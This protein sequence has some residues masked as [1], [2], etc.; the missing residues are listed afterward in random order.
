MAN[1]Y[2][3]LKIA[4]NASI[5]E[6]ENAVDTHYNYWRALVTHHDEK[7]R[8]QANQSLRAL[9]VIRATL[10]DPAKRSQYDTQLRLNSTTGGLVDPTA[11]PVSPQ[12]RPLPPPPPRLNR[13]VSSDGI[14]AWQCSKC[15]AQNE[16]GNLHCQTCGNSIGQRCPNCSTVMDI[17]A[18]FCPQCGENPTAFLQ[19]KE[20]ERQAQE[21]K[22]RQEREEREKQMI[23]VQQAE[24]VRIHQG[25][26]K[27]LDQIQLALNQKKYRIALE[28]LSDFQNLGKAKRKTTPSPTW[29][30]ARPEWEQARALNEIAFKQ[31]NNLILTTLPFT[32]IGS[33]LFAI[34]AVEYFYL[35]GYIYELSWQLGINSALLAGGIGLVL[36]VGGPIL[37]YTFLGG[38]Q[39]GRFDRAVAIASPIG[40]GI[41]LIVLG[42]VLYIIFIILVIVIFIFMLG[43]VAGG[44]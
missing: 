44:G 40:L 39:G 38:R 1:Y 29:N 12:A 19:K 18:S 43:A 41:L 9:E 7:M 20:Q 5:P 27:Q 42:I 22:L 23:L 6:I 26:A 31:K 16:K 21:L 35:G 2:E 13:T 34:I 33:I 8:D 4:P 32:A 30:Q 3:L 28:E 14:T 36:G 15:G 11:T 37:Y 25:I 24:Q 10:T 17:R